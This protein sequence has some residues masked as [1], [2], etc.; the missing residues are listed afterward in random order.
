MPPIDLMTLP[1]RESERLAYVEGFVK[2]AELFGRIADLQEALGQ[3][4]AEIALLQ[5]TRDD[6]QRT[7]DDLT[8]HEL[9][10]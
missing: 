1:A 3:A 4:V 7:V 9:A 6:L 10:P 5:E 8:S 2:T